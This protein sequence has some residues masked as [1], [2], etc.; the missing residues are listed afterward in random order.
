MAS[1]TR[2]GKPGWSFIPPARAAG[3]GVVA[4]PAALAGKGECMPLHRRTRD[5]GTGDVGGMVPFLSGRWRQMLLAQRR[6]ILGPAR[7]GGLAMTAA[8]TACQSQKAPCGRIVDGQHVQ[9]RD[10]D[11]GLMADDYSF[12]SASRPSLPQFLSAPY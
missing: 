11:D 10:E 8:T 2:G 5:P 7:R 6:G 12:A 1:S 9:D 4:T 3:R